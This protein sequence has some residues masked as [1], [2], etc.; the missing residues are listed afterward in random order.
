M[1]ISFGADDDGE[2]A[3]AVAVHLHRL[4]HEV[5]RPV[6][7]GAPWPAVGRAVGEAV[8]EGLADRGIVC[9]FTGTGVTIAA[10]KV[11]GVRAALCTDAETAHGARRW[12][13]ANVLALSMQRTAPALALEIVDAFLATEVDQVEQAAIGD[14]EGAGVS[15][16]ASAPV[17]ELA[18]QVVALVAAAHVD[19]GSLLAGLPHDEVL[20]AHVLLS[21]RERELGPAS[22][23][24]GLLHAASALVHDFIAAGTAPPPEAG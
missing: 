11:P 16:A 24:H 18:D 5:E 17:T 7:V 6:R 13:D 23:G 9:C 10:N 14:L 8:A 21:Q 1:R 12:N 3:D 20:A 4:G 22:P 2:L 15:D 19:I